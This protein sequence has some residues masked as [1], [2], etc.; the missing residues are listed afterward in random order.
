MRNA[1][2]ILILFS[3]SCKLNQ[4]DSHF[5]KQGKWV[6]YYDN[7]EKHIMNHGHYLN[8]QQ[9]GKW[10]YYNPNGGIYLK[11]TYQKNNWKRYP[12]HSAL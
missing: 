6:L 7:S 1:F 12:S 3:L 5:R 11:E 4:V 9:I 10:N 2:F 8:N